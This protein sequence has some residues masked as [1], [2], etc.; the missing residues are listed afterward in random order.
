MIPTVMEFTKT[1][2]VP[3][4]WNPGPRA[5]RDRSAGRDQGCKDRRGDR[6]RVFAPRGWLLRFQPQRRRNHGRE[7]NHLPRGCFLGW[8]LQTATCPTDVGSVGRTRVLDR[9]GYP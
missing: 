9:L 7:P 6:E 8:R 2:K 4:G 1:Q 5:Y 3:D